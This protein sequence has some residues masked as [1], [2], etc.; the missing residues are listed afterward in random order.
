M[1]SITGEDIRTVDTQML[2]TLFVNRK[3][4]NDFI[5]LNTNFH[6]HWLETVY[7]SAVER[8]KLCRFIED[9]ILIRKDPEDNVLYSLL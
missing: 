8:V 1:G 2:W 3:L 4:K 6:L 5:F 7:I 9:I